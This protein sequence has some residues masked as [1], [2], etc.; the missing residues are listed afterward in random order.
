MNESDDDAPQVDW[1]P[2]I[3]AAGPVVAWLKGS[4]ERCRVLERLEASVFPEA[5]S[6]FPDAQLDSSFIFGTI[7]V[8][9]QIRHVVRVSRP[10]ASSV[11]SELPFF[12]REMLASGQSLTIAE[13]SAYYRHRRVDPCNSLSVET[14]FRVGPRCKAVGI[15]DL[16]YMAMFE[17]ANALRADAVFAHINGSSIQSFSRIGLDWEP[18][19]GRSDVCS[20]DGL[21]GY[22][23]DYQPIFIPRTA[24]NLRILSSLS[25]LAPRA[26]WLSRSVST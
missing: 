11:G 26:V 5:G 12:F 14:N 6:I 21:G 13:I 25:A 9:K 1:L 23:A 24:N 15:A 4:D 20:P 2:G 7:I 16:A 3:E 8:G 19:L 22:D 18:L 17:L 10:M